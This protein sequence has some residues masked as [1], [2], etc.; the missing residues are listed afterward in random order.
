MYQAAGSVAGQPGR[1][2][3]TVDLTKLSYSDLSFTG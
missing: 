3:E 1:Q 2:T